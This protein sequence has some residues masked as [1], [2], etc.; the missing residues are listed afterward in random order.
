M[1]FNLFDPNEIKPA[2][3]D[4]SSQAA[5]LGYRR[6]GSTGPVD[7]VACEWCKLVFSASLYGNRGCPRCGRKFDEL[8]K[9]AAK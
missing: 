5:E 6:Y 4:I 2:G 7:A 3:Q 8:L 1:K 9:R